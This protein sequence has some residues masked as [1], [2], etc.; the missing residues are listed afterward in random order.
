MSPNKADALAVCEGLQAASMALK[1]QIAACDP[2]GRA[3]TLGVTMFF[4]W[5]M[6]AVSEEDREIMSQAALGYSFT[7]RD[8]L[9]RIK[10]KP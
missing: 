3:F 7:I 5:I 9:E 8:A 4:G 2:E 6:A 1:D 10:A